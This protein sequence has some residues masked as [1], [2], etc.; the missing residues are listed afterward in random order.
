M[1][2]QQKRIWIFGLVLCLILISGWTGKNF[3][4]R[5]L[6][7]G[8]FFYHHAGQADGTGMKSLPGMDQTVLLSGNDCAWGRSFGEDQLHSGWDAS[9]PLTPFLFTGLQD[10]PVLIRSAND[11]INLITVAPRA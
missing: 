10:L 1:M 6:D 8:N 5:S 9:V 11:Q 4:I 3:S 7:T 2:K